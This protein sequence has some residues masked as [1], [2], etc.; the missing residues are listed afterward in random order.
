MNRYD[1][2]VIGG[3]AAGLAAART[4]A[5]RDARTL[6][7]AE[8]PIGGDCTFTGCVPSKT[9]IEC[10]ARGAEFGEAMP[11]VRAAVA[12]IAAT[13]T[14][15]VLAQEGIEVLPGR[16]AFSTPR[17]ILAGGSEIEAG[18]IIIATGTRPAVPPIPGL[19]AVARL[20]NENV[21]ELRRAPRSL[22]VLGGGAVGCELSQAM[23][24]LGV[25]ITVVEERDRL[26]PSEDPEASRIIEDVLTR[27]PITIRTATTVSAVTAGADGIRLE[28]E[29]GDPVEAEMLLVAAGRVPVTD[30]LRLASAGV[31][32]D[33]R[34]YVIVD[35]HLATTAAGV[36]AAGDITGLAH[37]THAAYAM[38][39][40][41]AAN[42]LGGRR[43]ASFTAAGIPRVVFTDPEVAQVGLTERQAAAEAEDALVAYL[44]M[45]ELDRAVAAGRTD[46]FV[47]LIA[48]P[49][50]LLRHRGGG[51]VLG[52]TIVASRAG[53]MIHEPA[54]AI[55]TGMFTGRLA[56]TVHAYPTW[57]MA[58]QQAAAQDRKSV[59]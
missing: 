15:E 34:G 27:E 53:E 28:T 14:A 8:G 13:E 39:R 50:R 42:A 51:R 19:A 56:Q 22:A 30:A 57:S 4:G 6:L 1:L 5:A 40:T 16:A 17:R 55:R 45:N 48:G 25:R 35:D 49:R 7:V 2:V 26:L 18:A 32:V 10:A 41:A 3:G 11:A 52:S 21:F 9:L 36:Y 47:K 54:L 33:G 31:G 38:G 20:T 37:L 24:R 29:R 58:I 46:G 59:V 44:P 43:K 23:S 12:R